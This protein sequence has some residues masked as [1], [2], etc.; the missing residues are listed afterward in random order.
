M[1]ARSSHL[2]GRDEDRQKEPNMKILVF[3]HGTIVMHREALGVSREER[4]RQ[5]RQR[6]PSVFDISNYVS[7]GQAREKLWRWHDLGAQLGYLGPSRRPENMEKNERLLCHLDFPP[8]PLYHRG[9]DESYAQVVE[10]VRP[11]IYIEDDCESIGGEAEMATPRL[12]AEARSRI[13]CII[14]LEF[15][16]IDHLPDDPAELAISA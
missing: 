8:G 7:V 1:Q 10:R 2:R 5:V 15:G 13:T 4:V 14:V 12:G 16:G 11:D 6:T 3:T 9:P